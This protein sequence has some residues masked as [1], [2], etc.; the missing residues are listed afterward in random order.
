MKSCG[1]EHVAGRANSNKAPRKDVTGN[2][3]AFCRHHFYIVGASMSVGER[4]AFGCMILYLVTAQNQCNIDFCWYDIGPCK[5]KA[6][7]QSVISIK[8]ICVALTLS[9]STYQ[10]NYSSPFAQ[11][12]FEKWIEECKWLSPEEKKLLRGIKFPLPPFHQYCHEASC[13]C[14]HAPHL[15]EGAGTA[16]GEPPEAFWALFGKLSHRIALMRQASCTRQTPRSC[17]L[18]NH[19]CLRTDLRRCMDSVPYVMC[20]SIGLDPCPTD[21]ARCRQ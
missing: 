16:A 14:A 3:A 9:G 15:Y 20:Q 13:Q 8:R 19:L 5:F 4:Y 10:A 12:Y 6:R 2:F 18:R 7:R 1:A 11:A 17:L 21:R